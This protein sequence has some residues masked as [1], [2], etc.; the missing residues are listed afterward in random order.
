FKYSVKMVITGENDRKKENLD[1]LSEI[2]QVTASNPAALQD[3]RLMKILNMILEE[4]GYSPL[5]INGINQT[6]TNPA[7]NP[8]N[9]GGAGAGRGGSPAEEAL[10]AASGAGPGN[11]AGG[12]AQNV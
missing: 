2:Y 6:P 12:A 10:A 7:L 8:A 1:T 9:Q 4:S 3:P 5:A 11:A